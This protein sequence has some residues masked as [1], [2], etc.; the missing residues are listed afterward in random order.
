MGGSDVEARAALVT[1]YVLGFAVLRAAIGSTAAP[2]LIVSKLGSAIQA[3]LA[4]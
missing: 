2:E 4:S 1:A 3:T